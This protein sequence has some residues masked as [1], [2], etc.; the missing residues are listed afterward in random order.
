MAVHKT[1]S[2]PLLYKA[3]EFMCVVKQGKDRPKWRGHYTRKEDVK[4]KT[5]VKRSTNASRETTNE[6]GQ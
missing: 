3:L 4:A 1:I 2:W 6:G 5:D